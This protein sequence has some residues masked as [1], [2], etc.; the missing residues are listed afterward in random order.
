[1]NF[2]EFQN[3]SRLYVVGA[4]EPDELAKFE[5]A[6]QQFGP[7]AER[8]ITECYELQHAFVLTLKPATVRADIGRRLLSQIHGRSG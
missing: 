5:A 6:R 2:E 3:Q 1:M 7:K 4:L 8:V